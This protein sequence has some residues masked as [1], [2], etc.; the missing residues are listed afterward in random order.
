MIWSRM[1]DSRST[2]KVLSF[3][4]L[5]L[6]EREREDIEK[7]SGNIPIP[8]FRMLQLEIVLKLVV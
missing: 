2:N 4:L 3:V 8:E 6:R 1:L 5:F 7:E